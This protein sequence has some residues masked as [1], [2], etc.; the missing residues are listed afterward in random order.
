MNWL[1][2]IVAIIFICNMIIG[3]KKGFVRILFSLLGFVIAL[4]ITYAVTP[5]IIDNF[6]IDSSAYEELRDKCT[7]KA[8]NSILAEDEEDS[9]YGYLKIFGIDIPEEAGLVPE[10]A[11]SGIVDSILENMGVYDAIGEKIARIIV[12][13]VVF[14]LCLLAVLIII[15]ALFF[16]IEA[17]SHLPVI[18]TANRMLGMG[19]G[20]IK[21]LLTSWIIVAVLVLVSGT[22]I[23]NSA[24]ECINN[25]VILEKIYDTDVILHLLRSSV[26]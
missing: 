13:A 22:Q 17:A 25:S 21:A 16:V 24:T 23:G 1:L 3:W 10:S 15:K 7:Q 8:R 2:I 11:D 20:F 18:N 9:S 26:S 5:V 12:K 14:A 19:L 4:G 6:V